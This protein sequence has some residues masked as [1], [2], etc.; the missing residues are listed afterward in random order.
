MNSSHDTNYRHRWRQNV[1]KNRRQWTLICTGLLLAKLLGLQ[2]GIIR[3]IATEVVDPVNLTSCL[4]MSQ[5]LALADCMCL[6]RMF[7]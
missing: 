1:L 4:H 5:Y 7:Q 6:N 3:V 2:E